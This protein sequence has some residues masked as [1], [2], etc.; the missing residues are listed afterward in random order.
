M[1]SGPLDGIRILEFT[2]I[3]AGPLGCMLLSDMGAEVIKVEPLEGE[4]WRLN[5]QF[6]PLE[7]KT[8]Q[9][10]NRGKQSLS[11]D[12]TKTQS[13]EAIHRLVEHA[14]VV[15]INYRPDVAGQ[16][17]IDYETLRKLRPDLVYVD[18]T[19][20]GRRGPLAQ[21]PGYD[22]VIQAATG[23]AADGA[24]FDDRGNP[25]LPGGAVVDSTTGYAIAWAV[26]AALFHRERTGRGQLVETSLFANGLMMQ[27]GE[28]MSLPAADG[29]TR[30]PFIERLREAREQARPYREF[31]QEGRELLRR[32]WGGNVYYRCYNTMNGAIAIGC[33]SQSLREKM[34]Q[35]LDIEDIRDEPGYD[36]MAPESMAFAERLTAQVEAMI[37]AQR[38]EHWVELFEAT[39]VPVSPLEFVQDLL[40]KP[41][42]A[43]NGYAAELEH[44]L[45]GP[46]WQVAP[47][48]KMSDSPPQP[49]GA[50]PPLGR[51]NDRVLALAGYSS[52][53]IEAMRAAGAIR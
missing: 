31:V 52:E 4:P 16:L 7:S 38:T 45:T 47:P 23:I 43:E 17:N 27:H 53:E 39:G 44:D 21:R 36:M 8:Y 1:A 41:Q 35:A 11:I 13:Q 32:A 29:D 20:F 25:M 33:L 37:A 51:D 9:A 24:R 10:L 14:D 18:S 40:D 48:I 42:V 49:Q 50:S 22:I 12:L 3:I 26:C 46:Q 34:R 19:A 30:G 5:R 6:V 28:F 15:V 2:Q